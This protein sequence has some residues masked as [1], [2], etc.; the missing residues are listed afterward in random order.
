MSLFADRL[1]DTLANLIEDEPGQLHKLTG[2]EPVDDKAFTL[3]SLNQLSSQVG[4]YPFLKYV[5]PSKALPHLGLCPKDTVAYLLNWIPDPLCKELKRHAKE[6]P[7]ELPSHT[8]VRSYIIGTWSKF[9]EAIGTCPKVFAPTGQID[10]LLC[11]NETQLT[12]HAYAMALFAFEP[13]LKKFIDRKTRENIK[14]SL[15]GITELS[16]FDFIR[17]IQKNR[18]DLRAQMPYSFP[19]QLW[20]GTKVSFKDLCEKFGFACLARLIAGESLDFQEEL[21][22]HVSDAFWA[23]IPHTKEEIK[24]DLASHLKASFELYENYLNEHFSKSADLKPQREE[25]L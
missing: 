7:I 14:D 4:Q 10:A 13:H 6:K 24:P 25:R 5:H 2:R 3:K 19:I 22:L 12:G 1:F 9:I 21:K 20:D 11:M 8:F 17:Y 18:K 15:S 16:S 23:K